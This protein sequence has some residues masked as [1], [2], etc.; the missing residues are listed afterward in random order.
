MNGAPP[1]PLSI[2]LVAAEE[3]GDALG[4]AL[5]RALRA[6]AGGALTLAGVGGRAMAAEGVVSP[7][8]D[9]R[10]RHRRRQRHTG[11]AAADLAAHSRNRGRRCRGATRRAGDHRQPGFHPPRGA[12]RARPRAVDS[13]R[14][15]CLAFGLG[16]AVR[17]GARHARLCRLRARDPAVRAGGAPAPR[18]AA[19]RLCGPPTGRAPGRSPPRGARGRAPARSSRRWCWS[20]PAAARA[21]YACCLRSL[22]TPSRA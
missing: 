10:T 18:R 11:A 17:P 3:S 1:R 14:R 12:P 22:A 20:C 2:Y 16:L 7:F 5:V 9:R 19:L 4:A 13:D 21:K 15:L 8:S 6:A